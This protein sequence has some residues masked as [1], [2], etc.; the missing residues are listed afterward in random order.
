[1]LVKMKT[2]YIKVFLLTNQRNMCSFHDNGKIPTQRDK[3]QLYKN[4]IRREEMREEEKEK[5]LKINIR[6]IL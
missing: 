5:H 3:K 2:F 6:Y 4:L 1:M